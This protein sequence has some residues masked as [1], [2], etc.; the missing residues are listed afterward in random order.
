MVSRESKFVCQFYAFKTH[1]F[2]RKSLLLPKVLISDHIE[3]FRSVVL[4][5]SE[6]KLTTF[7]ES[8]RAKFPPWPKNG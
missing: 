4:P 7:C 2:E 8:R 5:F 6:N 1:S 3:K